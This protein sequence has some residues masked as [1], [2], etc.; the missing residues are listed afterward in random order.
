[1]L[2]V[3]YGFKEFPDSYTRCYREVEAIYNAAFTSTSPMPISINIVPGE[4]FSAT[5]PIFY[6]AFGN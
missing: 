5:L 6:D 4:P 1:L 2:G 3:E